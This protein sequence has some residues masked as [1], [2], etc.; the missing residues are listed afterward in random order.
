MNFQFDDRDNSNSKWR[1]NNWENFENF[2]ISKKSIDIIFN[3]YQILPYSFGAPF[4]SI[5]IEKIL[6][7][8]QFK[9]KIENLI[10]ALNF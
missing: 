1:Y 6:E 7:K 8:L 3:Q 9:Y 2:L 10:I 5:P 4:V